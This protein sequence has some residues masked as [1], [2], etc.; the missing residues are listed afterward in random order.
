V[1]T[2]ES[3]L[4]VLRDTLQRLELNPT[5]EIDTPLQAEF[6]RILRARIANLE[7]QSAAMLRLVSVQGTHG[8]KT[9][10]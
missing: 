4:V 2:Q 9:V 1:K 3:V 5:S 6:K 7:A 10:A 8:S